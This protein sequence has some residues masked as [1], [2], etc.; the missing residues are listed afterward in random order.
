MDDLLPLVLQDGISTLIVM[1]DDPEA[2][3]RFAEQVMPP[4]RETVSRERAAAA[5]RPDSRG[6]PTRR[7]GRTGSQ[8]RR[9]GPAPGRHRL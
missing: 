9:A 6:G 4:L 8:R 1:A 7:A 2:M 5:P 3:Q